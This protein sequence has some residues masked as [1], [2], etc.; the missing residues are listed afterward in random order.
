MHSTSAND[1]SV[2]VRKKMMGGERKN[3]CNTV[4]ILFPMVIKTQASCSFVY[5]I[6]YSHKQC[7]HFP[8]QSNIVGK[9]MINERRKRHRAEQA[10]I[11]SIFNSY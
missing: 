10:L 5:M 4:S 2:E 6:T 1:E 3:A 7:F 9:V 11:S 8:I